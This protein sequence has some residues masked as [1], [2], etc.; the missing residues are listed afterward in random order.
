MNYK[1]IK[2]VTILG[3]G[4]KGSYYIANFLHMIGVEI[5]GYDLQGSENT[6]DLE[7]LGIKINYRNPEHGEKLTGDFYLYT[8]DIPQNIQ[9]VIRKDNRGMKSYEIGTF[10]HML[11]KDF[12]NKRMSKDIEEAFLKSDVAPLFKV[13]CD[14]MKYIGITG[15][16]GKTT[17]CTMV[18]HILK[19]NG[20]KPALISTV[21]AKIGD[22]DI[23]TGFHTT[24]PTSQELYKLIKKV[25]EEKCTHVIIESTS[26]GLHQGRLAGLKFDIVG[27]TNITHEH[28]DYHKT[29][30]KYVD[31]KSLLIREH[32]KDK[33]IV[34]LNRDDK[35][36][37]ILKKYAKNHKDYSIRKETD[38][39]GDNI[40]D[41]NNELNFSL[42]DG[43]VEYDVK[44]PLLGIYNVSNFLLAFGITRELGLKTEDI[45]KSV[46]DFKT[47]EG[48]MQIIQKDPF[49]V[50]VDYAH[51]PNAIKE[52][53]ISARKLTKG[54][55]IHVF[56]SAGHRD[57]YKRP[58]MGK[59]SN[60]LADITI[61]TAEDCRQ[62]KLSDI[63]DAIEKGWKKGKNKDAKLFRFD[64]TSN[65]V[66][67]RI[68]AIE[69]ALELAE[70]G[71]LIIITGKA[72]EKS[73][74][75]EQTE[76]PWN[77]IDEVKKLLGINS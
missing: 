11:I 62:E 6:K 52:V 9:K 35:A 61:L 25:E 70:K 26:H 60:E 12:E 37:S 43:N 17:S 24:T 47:V 2:K 59:W 64:D 3:I 21:S 39:Y 46:S 14:K 31:A 1:D 30:R 19:K 7:N 50:I 15:T 42:Y 5:V 74:C 41:D 4:G 10:Y 44:L 56:G 65:N 72:H 16:D 20:F 68:D 32:L 22:K 69:K 54:R 23:D 34:I 29:W 53:L 8:N 36:Y 67:V 58:E 71:D 45:I 27:Y 76:Y 63:N 49:M 40:V 38:L 48:R 33:G 18:Y 75:F 77:D 13:D 28:L 73:L 55:I 51:T 66:Q 57:Q